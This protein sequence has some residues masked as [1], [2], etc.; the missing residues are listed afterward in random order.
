MGRCFFKCWHNLWVG[1]IDWHE[2]FFRVEDFVAGSF[3]FLV[4]AVNTSCP[5]TQLSYVVL[6][7][8]DLNDQL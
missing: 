7:I 1:H 5:H 4:S 3:M 2:S 8:V 6:V